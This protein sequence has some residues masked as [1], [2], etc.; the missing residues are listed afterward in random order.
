MKFKIGMKLGI[1]FATVLILMIISSG[2]AYINSREIRGIGAL[3]ETRTSTEKSLTALQ[4]DLNQT[5]SKGRQAVL[6]GAEQA[7]RDVARKAFNSAWDDIKKDVAQLDELAPKWSLQENRD[8]WVKSKE[9]L[10]KLR[11]AQEASMDLAI[12]T[13]AES[14]VKGG[15]DFADKATSVNDP[16]K[17]VLQD[18]T[19]SFAAL[20]AQTNEQLAS[21]NTSMS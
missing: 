4:R 16:L 15:N 14:V 2:L 1:G 21:A 9:I 19:D 3:V 17:A 12:G 10:P 11:E 8:L 5:Q 20:S 7:R 13:N 18:M 6:A